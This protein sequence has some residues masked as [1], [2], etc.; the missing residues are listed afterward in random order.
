[1]FLSR[2][3]LSWKIAIP[4]MVVFLFMLVMSVLSLETLWTTMKAERIASLKHLTMSAK[5]IALS[6]YQQEQE[7]KFSREEAQ[8][9][10]KAA[11]NTIR[12]DNGTGYIF[13]YDW[14]GTNLVLPNKKLVGKNLFNMQ[15]ANGTYLIQDLIAAAKRG[16]DSVPYLWE[17]PGSDV[18]VAKLSWAEAIEDWEWMLGTGVYIDDLE[19]QF[20]ALAMKVGLVLFISLL[21]AALVAIFIIRSISRPIATLIGNMHMLANGNADISVMETDRQ[22]E[23]G[24]MAQAMQV[25]VDNEVSRKALEADRIK[26]QKADLDRGEA[27]QG[28]C[29]AFEKDIAA[30]LSTLGASSDTL[31]NASNIMSE[32]AVNTSAQS[33]QVSA[34]SQQASANVEAL[35][36]VASQ[37][38]ASV[39]KITEQ[40]HSSND[41]TVRVGSQAASANERVSRLANSAGHISEIV[42]LI[43]AIAE[44]TN[45]LALNATIEAARA[46]EAGKGFAVV[47]AEVKGL[48]NQTSKA[49]EEID[50]KVS[51]IQIETNETVEAITEISNTIE[52]L[53]DIST[54]IAA[55]VEEQRAATQ[56]IA[57]NVSQAAKGTK[58]V[59]EN[60]KLVSEEADQT[61]SAAASV[62]NASDELQTK[63]SSLRDQVHTFLDN[64]RRSSSAS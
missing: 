35:A 44:Q 49:T 45:L 29:E 11:I 63:A 3:P 48:A 37:L 46:G 15:D 25:F 34:A 54:Q 36:S 14:Q 62:H 61:R 60:I 58:D 17:K 55:A 20:Y 24:E 32:N 16:G 19:A 21:A 56:D 9:A 7:G 28:L 42:T 26:A 2:L 10:A 6:F 50:S 1:M 47:A 22:D 8:A 27:V 23:V 13:V 59:T 33:T 39:G 38:A 31:Q 43:Q 18:P 40:V 64:V 53:G 41:M 12:Y 5:T 30:L 4:T 51:E 52:S 57:T